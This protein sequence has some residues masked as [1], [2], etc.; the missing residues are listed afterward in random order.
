MGVKK[1]RK[2]EKKEEKTVIKAVFGWY[3]L[4]LSCAD[5]KVTYSLGF[6]HLRVNRNK[7]RDV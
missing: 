6:I 1:E 3:N 2:K 4:L 7:L 5:A